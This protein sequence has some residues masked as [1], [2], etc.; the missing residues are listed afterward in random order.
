MNNKPLNIL[1]VGPLYADRP[2]GPTKSIS[3]LASFQ[4]MQGH[5]VAILPAHPV[6]LPKL[7]AHQN[8]DRR[9]TMLPP[10]ASRVL[11]P[12][13]VSEN[14][15]ARIETGFCTP[16]IVHIHDTYI[17]FQS[18]LAKQLHRAGWPYI[19]SP[20]GGCM[21]KAQGKKKIKK[22]LGNLLFM[23][24]FI[25][26]ASKVSL[27]CKNEQEE[28]AYDNETFIIPNGI[29]QQLFEEMQALQENA[30]PISADPEQL[31]FGFMGRIDTY[32]KGIDLLLLAVTQLQQDGLAENVRVVLIGPYHSPQE[33]Q[34]VSAIIEKMPFAKNIILTGTLTGTQKWK[35]MLKFDIFIHTSRFEGMPN[36]VLEAMALGKACLVSKG[37]NMVDIVV[38]NTC[39]WGCDHTVESVTAA[40]SQ[41][42]TNEKAKIK[43][44]GAN[45]RKYIGQYH[46]M[47]YIASQYVEEYRKICR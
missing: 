41:I 45:A 29:S 31:V 40:M 37:S 18:A 14:W 13:F 25:N 15:L 35:E 3:Q 10:P 17:P 26:Q 11:N 2:T 36:S 28:F 38:G 27:L 5:N 23:D 1:H 33:E 39:G 42:I 22:M 44:Y 24:S 16:D 7:S 34:K 8:I 4:A 47:P 43:D 30:P 21:Q 9:I 46:L 12:W 19:F 20:R 6:D 32:H